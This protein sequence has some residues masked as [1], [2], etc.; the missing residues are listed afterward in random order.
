ME[1]LVDRHTL[2]Y[3]PLWPTSEPACCLAFSFQHTVSIDPKSVCHTVP[4]LDH[5]QSPRGGK[6]MQ[7]LL[8]YRT[9]RNLIPQDQSSARRG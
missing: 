1:H 8:G 6:E 5:L 3:V 9:R 4:L 7:C 2:S